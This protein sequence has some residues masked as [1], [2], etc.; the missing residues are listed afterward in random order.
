MHRKKAGGEQKHEMWSLV[1][2]GS[3]PGDTCLEE[4][5]QVHVRLEDTR[6]R[7]K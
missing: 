7:A 5:P 4:K 2:E 6:A 3:R 1:P